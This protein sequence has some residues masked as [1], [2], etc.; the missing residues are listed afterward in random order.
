LSTLSKLAP[1]FNFLNEAMTLILSL[2]KLYLIKSFFFSSFLDD[3]T[4]GVIFNNAS[5]LLPKI[6]VLPLIVFVN[7]LTTSIF[8]GKLNNKLLLL[9]DVILIFNDFNSWSSKNHERLCSL[10]Q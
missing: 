6:I 10:S 9:C 1:C 3:T 4:F 8:E 2:S 7:C 5:K